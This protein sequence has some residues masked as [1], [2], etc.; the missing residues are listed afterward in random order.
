[1]QHA[2]IERDFV[3]QKAMSARAKSSVH[4][5]RPGQWTE[6][7]E[8]ACARKGLHLTPLRRQI[9]AILASAPTPLGAYAI[10]EQLSREQ[11]LSLIH[12]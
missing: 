1:M 5:R 9:L 2:S 11:H 8:Q 3:I 10:I 4:A 6:L 7:V 12:I